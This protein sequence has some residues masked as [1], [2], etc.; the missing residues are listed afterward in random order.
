MSVDTL[1]LSKAEGRGKKKKKK[2]TGEIKCIT[3]QTGNSTLPLES[4]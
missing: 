4:K 3:K 1:G 2:L